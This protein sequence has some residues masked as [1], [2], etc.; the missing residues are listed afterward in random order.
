MNPS[1]N[2]HS[3]QRLQVTDGQLLT[4]KNWRQAHDY[5][6]QRQN[7]Y[8]Q[9]LH[10]A[11]IVW[12]LGVSVIS[13]SPAEAPEYRDQRWLQIQP[14]VAID[15]D[16]NP[17]IV[18]QPMTFRIA[19]Q[20]PVKDF[21][22]VYVVIN[23]V[24]PETLKIT[25]NSQPVPQLVQETFRIDEK[26]APPTAKD[27][28]LCRIVLSPGEVAL[29]P[30]TDVLNPEVN[31]LDLRY[32]QQAQVRSR[33]QVRIAHLGG[34]S[35]NVAVFASLSNLVNSV[36]TL[37]PAMEVTA[38]DQVTLLGSLENLGYD[39][40]YLNYSQLFTFQ[41]LEKEHLSQYLATGAVAL[42]E[43]SAQEAN[44]SDLSLIKQQLQT[45]IANLILEPEIAAIKVELET[46]LNAVNTNISKRLREIYQPIQDLIS[47]MSTT[48]AFSEII[49]HNHPLRTQPFLFAQ[50]PIVQG[51][52]IHLF[53]C[54]G[55]ILV[56]GALS[57][58][59]GIDEALSLPRE[60]IRTAQEMGI[61]ILH[62]ASR[63]HQL[64]QWQKV[65]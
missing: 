60:T 30:A 2:S 22:V 24:D 55:V 48:S 16:G 61:N 64:T 56:I 35:T 11:G 17:I 19:S 23:F 58:S 36:S 50:L 1:P 28:E 39:L 18:P 12:G 20:P 10:Q 34:H 9:S 15:C 27:V 31:N 45:A 62:F 52:P 3:L 44:I 29:V 6:R 46:E 25:G 4:A 32:R 14:G 54:S 33:T 65:V 7:L 26:I 38:V 53:Y 13:P 42:I 47:Q 63:R 5:H 21:L 49:P 59:W 40:L 41:E 37:Y 43:I 57:S 51:C 8:Y